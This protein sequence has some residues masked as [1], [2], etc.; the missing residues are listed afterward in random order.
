MDIHQT[1]LFA[2]LLAQAQTAQ[3]SPKGAD[4]R[5]TG[6]QLAQ[7]FTPKLRIAGLATPEHRLSETLATQHLL[8]QMAHKTGVHIASFVGLLHTVQQTTRL[9]AINLTTKHEALAVLRALLQGVSA[10][11]TESDHSHGTLVKDLVPHQFQPAHTRAFTANKSLV[12][13]VNI[14]VAALCIDN[15]ISFYRL[16]QI[17]DYLIKNQNLD[18]VQRPVQQSFNLGTL[19]PHSP[20]MF[21]FTALIN[22]RRR[23]REKSKKRPR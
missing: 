18:S 13:A 14:S 10:Q 23:R 3:F 20:S 19:T 5:I 6:D 9:Q 17:L 4:G 21:P 16:L 7:A 12:S 22:K 1:V 15:K 8:A 11:K 2:R